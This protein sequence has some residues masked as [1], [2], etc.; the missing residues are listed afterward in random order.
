MQIEAIKRQARLAG[1]LYLLVVII[2]PISLIYVPGQLFVAGDAAATAAHLRASEP[3]LRL[4]IL[5]ELSH[6]AIEV[7]LVLALY[8][9]FKRVSRTHAA[10]L[11]LFGLV[12]IPI[13]FLNALNEIAAYK[14]VSSPVLAAV[15]STAQLDAL[16]LFFI[17]LHGQ[18]I[19]IAAVFWGLWLLPFG[20]LVIRS[21]FIPKFLGVLLILAG[22]GY[23]I[24]STMTLVFPHGP[25]VLS[26]IAQMLE[27]GEPPIVIWLLIWGARMRRAT[28]LDAPVAT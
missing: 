7:G 14:L 4:G 15:F 22:A 10:L 23:V 24:G 26:D 8:N 12:P 3:L 20:W 27:M 28:L 6:Q 25:G 11:A 21:G 13:M 2:A 9:L 16:A 18:G 19:Q 5:C 17:Q 1:V